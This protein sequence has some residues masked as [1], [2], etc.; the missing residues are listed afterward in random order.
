MRNS[1]LGIGIIG[2]GG[3]CGYG[4][5][6]ALERARGA[7]LAALCDVNKEQCEA[8][9][10]LYRVP[11]VYCDYHELLADP[12]IDAVIVATPNHLHKQMAIDALKAGK[13]V[14]CEKPMALT[15][16]DA[17]EVVTAAQ[18]A[19]RWLMVDFT[20]RFWNRSLKLKE[21]I[22]GG[23]LGEVY[24]IRLGWLRRRG[25]PSWG[26]DC[27]FTRKSLSG[28]GCLVD[29]GCHMIDLALWLMGSWDVECVSGYTTQRFGRSPAGVPAGNGQDVE[30]FAAGSLTLRNGAHIHFEVAWALNLDREKYN[31]VDVYGTEAGAAWRSPG[32]NG[33]HT[34]QLSF[35][36][37]NGKQCRIEAVEFESEPHWEAWAR[38]VQ[39]FIDS[40]IL[41][42]QPEPSGECGLAVT[43]I[44]ESIYESARSGSRIVPVPLHEA[45]QL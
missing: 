16:A 19:C 44:I 3:I 23:R 24:Y 11:R 37:D 40:I 12:Q 17:A 27:W 36:Y 21:S 29:I 38:A 34:P 31:F 6:P 18:I 32:S 41:D 26:T 33:E 28:G 35:H 10:K 15:S 22:A 39:H 13:H 42:H 2:T 4:L 20:H 7:S 14:F 43:R 30:D 5:F 25:T 9:A 8:N 1:H 45:P